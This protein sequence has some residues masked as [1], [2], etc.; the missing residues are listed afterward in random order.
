[1]VASGGFLWQEKLERRMKSRYLS[2]RPWARA[3]VSSA[4]TQDDS[5]NMKIREGNVR[6][7]LA[8]KT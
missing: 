8:H 3:S 2:A 1:M 5:G 4:V 7:G 6:W